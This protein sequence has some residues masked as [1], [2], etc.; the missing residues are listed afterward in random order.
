MDLARLVVGAHRKQ[1]A[2]QLGQC[3][4]G[5]ARRGCVDFSGTDAQWRRSGRRGKASEESYI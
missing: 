2:E 4:R 5:R 3:R 1:C